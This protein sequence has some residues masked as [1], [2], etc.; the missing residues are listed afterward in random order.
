MNDLPKRKQIRLKDYDYSQNG[1]YFITICTY[2]KKKIFGIINNEK[3]ILND[4]GRIVEHTWKDLENH[5]N[6]K[7]HEYVIMPEHIHGIIQINKNRL[8]LPK[9]SIP[10]KNNNSIPEIIRQ[11]KSF[12]SRRINQFLNNNDFKSFSSGEL[13]QKSYYEHIIRDEMDYIE[14][15]EYIMNNPIKREME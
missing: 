10:E 1:F 14:K 3:T 8:Y 13:W 9:D 12:S 6:I 15:A 7:I 11:F 5:N 2:K 4:I